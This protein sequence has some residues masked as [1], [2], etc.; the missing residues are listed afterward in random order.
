MKTELA[1]H[2]PDVETIKKGLNQL[3]DIDKEKDGIPV[4]LQEVA[5]YLDNHTALIAAA[6]ET[7]AERDRLKA[8]NAELLE[9]LKNLVNDFDKSVI[10]TYKNSYWVLEAQK[11]VAKAE[12]GKQ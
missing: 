1:K 2:T 7:L 8:I 10:T 11:A 9:A 4:A 12:G 6:P 3:Q 5:E